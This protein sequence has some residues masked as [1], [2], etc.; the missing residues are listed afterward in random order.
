[1]RMRRLLPLLI[2]GI[3]LPLL[4]PPADAAPR[5][6]ARRA[7][8]MR[9]FE[10]SPYFTFTQFENSAEIDEAIGAGFRFG[11]LGTP[12]HEF[13]FL[14]ND[15]TTDDEVFPGVGIQVTQFQFAYVYNFT[16][17]EV[18]PYLTAGIGFVTVDD[19]SLGDETN[20]VLGLGG[21][22]KLFLGPAFFARFELRHNQF[23]G[24]LPVFAEGEAVSFR[25]LLFGV[26][27]RFGIP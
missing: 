10:F 16:R 19:T 27:W 1:M 3:A 7:A 23:E 24:D 9:G 13:E 20:P 17:K 5:R 21:G 15:V 18:V 25:E 8:A 26:G 22:L 4:A 6:Y 12:H 14:L 11:Y 2:T